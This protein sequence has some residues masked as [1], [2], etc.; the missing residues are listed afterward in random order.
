MP[1]LA[2]GECKLSGGVPPLNHKIKYEVARGQT[3]PHTRQR[4]AKAFSK[5][6]ASYLKVG[7]G[8][9]LKIDVE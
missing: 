2:S 7:V 8:E 4:R 1:S 9:C 5:Q 6:E 3:I